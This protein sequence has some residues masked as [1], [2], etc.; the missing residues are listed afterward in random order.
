[1]K[2]ESPRVGSKS[3]TC[4]NNVFFLF[5]QFLPQALRSATNVTVAEGLC[6]ALGAVMCGSGFPSA[7]TGLLALCGDRAVSLPGGGGAL[8]PALGWCHKVSFP[9]AHGCRL[10]RAATETWPR[11]RSALPGPAGL[12][13]EEVSSWPAWVCGGLG[14]F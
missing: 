7:G 14:G 4:H 2:R 12:P 5:L 1:M 10:P 6:P 13:S 8:S 11:T 9:L 3:H